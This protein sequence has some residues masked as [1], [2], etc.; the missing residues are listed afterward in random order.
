MIQSPFR[1]ALTPREVA[2]AAWYDHLR[3]NERLEE[4]ERLVAAGDFAGAVRVF[5]RFSFDLNGHIEIEE[6]VLFPDLDR[7]A[8][9]PGGNPTAVLRREHAEIRRLAEATAAAIRVRHPDRFCGA[10][11]ALRDVL[12]SH[13]DREERLFSGRNR[14]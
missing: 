12:E 6:R 4:T 10:I 1:T 13:T 9:S 7:A 14:S 8:E 11:G 5:D 2:D 3:L